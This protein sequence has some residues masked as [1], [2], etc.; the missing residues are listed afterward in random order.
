MSLRRFSG[1]VLAVVVNELRVLR[2]NRTSIVIS[3]IILPL[4]FTASLGGA[5]GG[6]GERFSPIGQVPIAFVDNDMTG[7]SG[8]LYEILVRSGNF[9]NL[10]EGYTEENAVSMLGTGRIFAAIIVPRGFENGLLRNGA[11]R[12]VVYV[13]DSV[14][15]LD[16]EILSALQKGLPDLVGAELREIQTASF[17][18]VEIIQK[19]ATFSGFAIGL[20]IVLGLVIIFST[21]YEIAGGISRECETGTYARFLLT[22]SSLQAMIVGK[23]IFDMFLNVIRVLMVVGIGVYAYGARLNADMGTV[24]A[25]SLLIALLTMGFGFL[26]SALGLGV[27]AIIIIE[28]FLVLFLF[29]FSGFIID[30]ELLTGI[31][32]A[33]SYSLPWAYGI[34]ILRRS[35]LIGQPLLTMT[36]QL[37]FVLGATA[38][39]YALAYLFLRLS[40]ERL[41]T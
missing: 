31:S 7:A 17:S 37:A 24:L 1:D 12:I 19:G 25:I 33:L 26:V 30:R 9:N 13:D 3:M 6:A 29:A 4:F 20:T 21:F 2:R 8:Q 34:E 41:V 10:I 15:G 11:S 22:P 39:F 36:R 23:T 5:S 18:Q 28:F 38:V 16:S 35:L 40:R 32:S 14:D 27:R